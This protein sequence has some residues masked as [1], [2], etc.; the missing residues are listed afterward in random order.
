MLRGLRLQLAGRLEERN[1]R[2]VEI[3]HVLGSDLTP[4][5]ADRLQ[6]G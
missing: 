2:D 5:L 1:E 3:E 6:E 4:E